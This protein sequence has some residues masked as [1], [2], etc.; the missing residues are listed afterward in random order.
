MKEFL[1]SIV[2]GPN[3]WCS[4]FECRSYLHWPYLLSPTVCVPML[5]SSD[6]Q[7]ESLW[8]DAEVILVP[9]FEECSSIVTVKWWV[10]LMGNFMEH[11]LFKT[12]VAG[13]NQCCAVIWFLKIID[14]FSSVKFSESKNHQ[15]WFFEKKIKIKESLVMGI[16]GTSKNPRFS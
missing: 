2:S 15:L 9:T 4:T 3:K 6:P 12:V 10:H 7:G 16:S 11:F 1:S 8:N 14:S 13:L 5:V